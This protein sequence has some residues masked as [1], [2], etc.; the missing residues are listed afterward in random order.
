[1]RRLRLRRISRVRRPSP[2]RRL[3]CRYTPLHYAAG[4][5]KSDIIAELL[6]RGA[7]GAVQNRHDG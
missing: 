4:N 6:L 5:G 7:D 1:M 2:R 3:P